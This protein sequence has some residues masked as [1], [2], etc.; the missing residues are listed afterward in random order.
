VPGPPLRRCKR[1]SCCWLEQVVSAVWVAVGTTCS[2]VA[3][4]TPL[5]Q[6]ADVAT[7]LAGLP[8]FSDIAKLINGEY[9]H[10]G[11]PLPLRLLPSRRWYCTAAHPPALPLPAS[12]PA[13][14]RAH[15]PLIP[16]RWPL[17]GA[18]FGILPG[19]FPSDVTVFL[20]VS[21]PCPPS[22]GGGRTLE[23]GW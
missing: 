12:Q 10:H 9:A 3:A 23:A 20:P 5:L 22:W 19:G 16:G 14:L 13:S 7:A 21:A 17:P 1:T 11:S 8:Q 2:T 18:G 6:C 15:I 4:A